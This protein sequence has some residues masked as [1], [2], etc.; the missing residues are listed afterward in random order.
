M[1][2]DD[3]CLVSKQAV[4]YSS[5]L[6][7]STN[8]TDFTRRSSTSTFTRVPGKKCSDTLVYKAK[9]M[10]TFKLPTTIADSS[11]KNRFNTPVNSSVIRITPYCSPAVAQK[12]NNAVPIS[13]K[14]IRTNT[15]I[16]PSLM[17]DWHVQPARQ[18][19][20]HNNNNLSN[21]DSRSIPHHEALTVHKTSSQP[22]S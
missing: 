11:G 1:A 5:R 3:G 2:P 20:K 7:S 18:Q 22:R 4:F 15:P 6:L 21:N 8:V 19:E 13:T 9:L 10:R 17:R 16:S 12:M 14:Q